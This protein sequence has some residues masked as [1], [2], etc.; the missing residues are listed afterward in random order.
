MMSATP[1]YWRRFEQFSGGIIS[2]LL[3]KDGI[4]LL[5]GRIIQM[6]NGFALSIL[7]IQLFGLAK[8]GTYTVASVAIAALAL[9]CSAGLQFSLPREP[10]SNEQRNTVALAW[11]LGL[12]PG[13]FASVAVF[14][15]VMAKLP[16][17]WIEIALFSLGG[18]FFG[19]M[20][21]LNTL[22]LLQ[23]RVKWTI[24][25][26][27]INSLGLVI[28]ALHGAS[29]IQVASILLLARAAGNLTLF[30]TMRYARVPVLAI[31][32]YGLEGFKY[33]PMD[34][35][36]LLSEQTGPLL[37]ANLLSRSELAIYGL[38]QQLLMAADAP[39]WS[40][41]QSYYPELVRTR[42]GIGGIVKARVLRL[43]LLM[44]PA[45][46]IA[47]VVLGS[48]VYRIPLFWIMTGALAASLPSRYL[49]NFYDQTLRAVGRI[50]TGTSLAA[51][52]LGL[53]L[54]LFGTLVWLGGL[55]GS[56]AALG[57]LS[58]ISGILYG[59]KAAPLLVKE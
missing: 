11:S 27:L 31:F 29:M 28:A 23:K 10:L 53:G 6:V 19:Q 2:A 3:P 22:L 34:L 9:L 43:S 5:L 13:L 57:L 4:I 8:V 48:Y 51:V 46:T 24:I 16:G 20:N 32:R 14:G 41:V 58:V 21:V 56:I 55:W 40:L 15:F 18:Y 7:L 44:T 42:L 47:A 26:P 54:L 33:S 37:L 45:V 1:S 52:K 30:Y 50:R 17:E 12:I 59:R 36:A 38:C 25:P 35:L 49:N 39:G